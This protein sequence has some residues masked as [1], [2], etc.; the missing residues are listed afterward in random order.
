MPNFDNNNNSINTITP[1]TKYDEKICIRTFML[2]TIK[3]LI[4]KKTPQ[5]CLKLRLYPSTKGEG[6]F[7]SISSCFRI[8]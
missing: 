8:L 6:W 2:N 5:F 4:I 7:L 1:T 3:N